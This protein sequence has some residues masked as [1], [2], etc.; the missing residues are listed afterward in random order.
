MHLFLPLRNTS[1]LMP[2]RG[3]NCQRLLLDH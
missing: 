1:S 3:I 2:T